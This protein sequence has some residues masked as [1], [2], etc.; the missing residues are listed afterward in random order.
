MGLCWPQ[1]VQGFVSFSLA[2]AMQVRRAMQGLLVVAP[3]PAAIGMAGSPAAEGAS[4]GI[5]DSSPPPVNTAGASTPKR[6][7]RQILEL[8]VKGIET[9]EALETLL[10][11]VYVACTGGR[12]IYTP[13]SD[14]VN[15][16]VLR[17]ARHF[18]M[19]RLHEHAARWLVK[20]LTTANVVD[21]LATC[22]EFGLRM[23]HDKIVEQL[24][25]NPTELTIV[26]CSPELT[27]HPRILQDI[28]VQVAMLAGGSQQQQQQ[29]QQ[30]KGT[31][32]AGTGSPSQPA[33]AKRARHAK[34]A[35]KA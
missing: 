2:A 32:S 30:R 22:E 10:S 12:W 28:L 4:G 19:P 25:A 8:H 31:S 24:T 16:D 21:R 18:D 20:D 5:S 13:T 33:A 35:A 3:R 34:N 14:L 9:S 7:Q 26:S 17:L 11:F 29:Q 1:Q 15:K 23:L 27:R 6:Q